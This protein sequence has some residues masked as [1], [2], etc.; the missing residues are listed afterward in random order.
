MRRMFGFLGATL[1]VTAL[2]ASSNVLADRSTSQ[3][4]ILE[5][6]AGGSFG[7][8]IGSTNYSMTS[9]GGEAVVGN[10]ASG[11]Y[12]LDQQPTQYTPSIQMSVQP[13]GLVGYYPLDEGTGK[14]AAD[15]SRY[16]HDGTL[17]STAAYVSGGKLGGAVNIN[18][19]AGSTGTGADGSVNVADHAN[20]PSGSQ[21]TFEAWV[22]ITDTTSAKAIAS[23]WDTSSQRSWLVYSNSGSIAFYV[24]T[25]PTDGSTFVRAGLFDFDTLNTWRHVAVVFDGTQSDPLKR[26]R[27]YIDGID[28]TWVD[29]GSGT[30]PTSL[31]DVTS[32]FSLGAYNGSFGALPGMIDHAKLFNRALSASE[33][34]A[35]YN[36]QNAGVPT[37]FG[38]Q[39]QYGGSSTS[40]YDA[41]VRTNANYT[42]SVQQDHDLQSGANT[43]APVSGSVASPSTWTEGATRGF[44]FTLTAAPSLDSKWASGTKYA[45]FPSSTTSVYSGAGTLNSTPQVVSLQMRLH[46]PD[47]QQYGAYTNSVT[48]TGTTTP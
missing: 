24:A 45:A 12:I 37:G 11:S 32:S 48:Y 30:M 3:S 14:T 33:I 34:A 23:Q 1:L 13:S 27:I 39:S 15:A 46:A 6:N 25:T 44:G 7:G 16:Q 5:G 22:N 43:I 8:T 29:H 20:L 38:I 40:A 41:I 26:A 21:L 28:K 47:A 10:G 2:L 4:Y 19:P 17:K 9:I 42:I 35:E 36:A 18:G 31:Q